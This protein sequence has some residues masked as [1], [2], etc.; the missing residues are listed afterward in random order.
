MKKHSLIVFFFFSITSF[1]YANV[2]AAYIS[3]ASLNSSKLT[4]DPAIIEVEEDELTITQ[5]QADAGDE[6]N[7]INFL[8]KF[9]GKNGKKKPIGFFRKKDEK[10]QDI[11]SDDNIAIFENNRE[12]IFSITME[13]SEKSPARLYLGYDNIPGGYYYTEEIILVFSHG[14]WSPVFTRDPYISE[15]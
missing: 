14:T 1:F 13:K 7:V 2:S 11:F 6:S 10:N 12:Y 9:D 15:Y 5:I 4:F 3:E 8:V